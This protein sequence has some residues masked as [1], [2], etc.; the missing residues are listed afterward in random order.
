M[1]KE[2]Q[3]RLDCPPPRD[4]WQSAVE[5]AEALR[6][7]DDAEHF[8]VFERVCELAF[9]IL[10]TRPDRQAVLDHE[11]P[12]PPESVGLLERPGGAWPHDRRLT[13]PVR[14][15]VSMSTLIG[16]ERGASVAG[17]CRS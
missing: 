9:A 12:L 17:R 8:R 2:Q 13:C 1:T 10:A 7:A 14:T 15:C 16:C 11:E 5:D 4:S 6:D 3:P